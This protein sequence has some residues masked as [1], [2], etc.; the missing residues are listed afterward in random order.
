MRFKKILFAVLTVLL[1]TTSCGVKTS[2]SSTS[3]T[4]QSSDYSNVEVSILNDT[5]LYLDELES[6]SFLLNT[7]ISNTNDY[8][9]IYIIDQ[10][11]NYVTLENNKVIISPQ[12]TKN[13]TF[14]I[15]A[16]L[17]KDRSK[18]DS[19]DFI[20]NITRGLI[21]GTRQISQVVVT[22]NGDSATSKGISWFSSEDIV[23]SHVLVSKDE[24]FANYK[25]Y[26]GT[27]KSFTKY[28]ED[29]DLL[30]KRPQSTF[31]NHQA[32]LDNLEP[33]TRYYY[34]VGSTSMNLF[35]TVGSFK[36]TNPN[37]ETKIFLT[38]DTHIGANERPLANN[39]FYHTALSDAFARYDYIDLLVNTGDFVTQW[40]SGYS[41]YES[42]WA[43]AMNISPLLRKT[44]FVP[45]AGNHDNNAA[46]SSFDYSI[47]NHYSLPASPQPI[48]DGHIHGPNYSFDAG[49][50][51]IVVLNH[52]VRDVVTSQQNQWLD[53]DLT[54]SNKPWK[55]VFSHIEVPEA[56]KS[57]LEKHNV[58]LAYSGHEHFYKRTKPLVSNVAQ[59]MTLYSNDN[60]LF[61][62]QIGT[63]Y[64]T[65]STPGGADAWGEYSAGVNDF[66]GFGA[67]S[68]LV[69][70]GQVQTKWGMYTVLTI[71]QNQIKAEVYL[72]N[73]PVIT[74]PFKLYQTYGFIIQN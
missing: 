22:A 50:V 61:V 37:G 25:T 53:E 10:P 73:S 43:Y 3:T 48:N 20:V 33:E 62:N 47:A 24:K 13:Y 74:A 27:R 52:N 28:A 16:I 30:Y 57:I 11:D 51:H 42:E 19:K 54:A 29:D 64:I 67:L 4:P 15:T 59:T 12:V 17:N 55:I 68:S 31:Y 36:T 63:T 65:N 18:Y 32:L 21:I 40:S 58:Q 60:N 46:I 7:S 34:K 71:N 49:N 1:L 69:S 2:S 41:Y 14:T 8:D 66:D 70:F 26:T 9:L 35:S 38:T 56:T 72:R 39:R 45:V 23:E 5:V 6:N 44:T